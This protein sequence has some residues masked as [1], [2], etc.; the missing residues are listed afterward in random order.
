MYLQAELKSKNCKISC[1][2]HRIIKKMKKLLSNFLM[3]KNCTAL[4]RK[5]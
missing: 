4:K 2:Q 3:S 1:H 5:L